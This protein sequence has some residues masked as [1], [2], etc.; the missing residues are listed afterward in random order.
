MVSICVIGLYIAYAIPIFL[1]WR[2]GD[3]FEPS[4]VWNLGK[5]WKWM[6]PFA[7]IWIA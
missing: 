6:N 7:V 3:E 4:A 2:M 1:R 5:K